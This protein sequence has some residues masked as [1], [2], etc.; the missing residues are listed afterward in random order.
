MYVCVCVGC[1]DV[2]TYYWQTPH[3]LEK[4]QKMKGKIGKPSKINNESTFDSFVLQVL[5]FCL[6]GGRG[7]FKSISCKQIA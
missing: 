2:C 7:G 1:E 5:V 4:Q 6:W 3:H